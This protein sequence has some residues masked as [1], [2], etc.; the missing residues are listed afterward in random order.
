MINDELV[1]PNPNELDRNNPKSFFRVSAAILI[2]AEC[3]SGCSKLI[4]G[5][6]KPFCIISILYTTS[7]A[8]AIQHSCPVIDLVELTGTLPPNTSKIASASLP[9]P[10]GVDVACAL[11]Y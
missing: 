1:P 10:A 5:A 11:M 6:T 3:S 8:P 4:L 7:L 9:S 2:L